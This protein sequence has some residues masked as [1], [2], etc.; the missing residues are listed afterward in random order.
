MVDAGY[1]YR[2]DGWADGETLTANNKRPGNVSARLTVVGESWWSGFTLRG[3]NLSRTD[4]AA[5][6]DADVVHLRIYVPVSAQ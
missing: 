3:F 6:T 2:P 5:L 1:Q 4:G